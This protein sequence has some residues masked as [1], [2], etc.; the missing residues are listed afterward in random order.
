MHNQ[1][2]WCYIV[3]NGD[4]VDYQYLGFNIFSRQIMHYITLETAFTFYVTVSVKNIQYNQHKTQ[5]ITNKN[6]YKFTHNKG[7]ISHKMDHR[8]ISTT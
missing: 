1:Q 7:S 2:S 8:S 6:P 5:K 4:T 3:K